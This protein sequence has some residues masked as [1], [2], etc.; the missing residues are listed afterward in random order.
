VYA[1]FGLARLLGWFWQ[2][3][4]FGPAGGERRRLGNASLLNAT[5]GEIDDMNLNGIVI[6]CASARRVGSGYDGNCI[7]SGLE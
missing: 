4:D 3:D 6:R 5:I 7:T 1:R 2:T